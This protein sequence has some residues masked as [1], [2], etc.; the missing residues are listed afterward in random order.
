MR[1]IGA[2]ITVPPYVRPGHYYSPVTSRSDRAVAVGWRGLAP[3]G[4]DLRETEQVELARRLAPLM[5]ELPTAR[6]HDDNI[7]FGRADAAVLHAMLRHHRPAQ[8]MEIGSG[9]STAVALD[10]AERFQPD[11]RIICVEPEP[12]RLRSRLRPGDRVELIERPVQSVDWA[13][14]ATLRDGDLLF[15]DSTH[16]SK[17]GSDVVWLLLH[18][19]PRLNPGVIVQIHDVH[20]PFEYPEEWLREGRDWNEVYLVRAFLTHNSAWEMLLFTSW[21]WTQRPEVLPAEL[22]NLDNG[23]LWLRKTG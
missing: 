13:T 19:L 8:L 21:L 4:I 11:L 14:F 23:S 10:V 12:E 20:W 9:Y 1:G 22:R 15:I 2:A 6:W 3:A 16:V 17:A 18:V 7:Y 5:T